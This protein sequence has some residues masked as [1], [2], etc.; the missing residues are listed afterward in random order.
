MFICLNLDAARLW[1]WHLVLL[2]QLAALPDTHVSVQLAPDPRPLAAAVRLGLH[3]ERSVSPHHAHPA[4]TPLT[5]ADFARWTAP[6]AAPGL[7]IDLAADKIASHP[8]ATTLTPFYDGHPGEAAFWAALL[9][10]KAPALALHDS[11]T[12]AVLG[13]GLPGLERPLALSRSASETI[14]RVMTGLVKAASNPPP[15]RGLSLV[16]GDSA[17]VKRPGPTMGLARKIAG[18]GRRTLW[19]KLVSEPQWVVAWRRSTGPIGLPPSATL[20]LSRYHVLPDDGRR[21]YA[22][23]FLFA[24]DGRIDLFVED[25]PYATGR[26]VISVCSLGGDGTMSV[27]RPVLETS[28]HLSYPQLIACN[29]EIWM[30][31]ECSMSGKLTLYRAASYPDA[32]EP[33]AVLVDAPLHDATLFVHAG[34]FWITAAA[35]GPAIAPWG[36]SWDSLNLYSAPALLGPWTAH[37]A[38]PVLIDARSARPAGCVFEAGGKLYRPVQ[39]CSSYYGSV[40]GIAEV[41]RLDGEGYGQ[42]VVSAHSFPARTRLLGPHTLNRIAIP[43]GHIE[44]IDV[45]GRISD[46][47][48]GGSSV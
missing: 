33:A 31:P 36:S 44:A 34:R 15:L 39:D 5:A 7:V 1:R 38:N 10:G 25:F 43:G 28:F 2:D 40:L 37:S 47:R 4:F 11:D 32:W 21:Y 46:L 6:A 24:H 19:H 29:G 42:R 27:P 18:L 8:P 14:S 30:M 41:T 35:Q 22:D 16:T 48:A 23:P 3:L 20:E 13:I 9:S 45:Y 12:A 17:P 26:G